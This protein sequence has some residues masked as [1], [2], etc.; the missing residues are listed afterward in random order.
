MLEYAIFGALAFV[1]LRAWRPNMA[2][3]G[4]GFVAWALA[5][6]YGMSDELHQSFVPNRDANWLDVGFDTVGAAVGI[7]G[8]GLFL[9]SR[10]KRRE[11]GTT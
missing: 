7:L 10:F 3:V 2:G 4:V 9:Q 5:V 8:V 1:A 11:S 6:L